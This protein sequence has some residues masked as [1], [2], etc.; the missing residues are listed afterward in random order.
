MKSFVQRTTRATQKC[1]WQRKGS[2]QPGP[3]LRLTAAGGKPQTETLTSTKTPE[4]I[5]IRREFTDRSF[6]WL[7]YNN[8][9]NKH[10]ASLCFLRVSVPRAACRGHAACTSIRVNQCPDGRALCSCPESGALG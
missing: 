1:N 6:D 5:W 2:R 3:Q 4:W 7:L 8:T 9:Q 10:G